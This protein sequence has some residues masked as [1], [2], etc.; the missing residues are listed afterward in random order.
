[1]RLPGQIFGLGRLL[2]PLVSFFITPPVGIFA[3]VQKSAVLIG[4]DIYNPRNPSAAKD[5]NPVV[6]R[7]SAKGNWSA[8][9]F[10][11][12]HGAVNDVELI[13]SILSSDKLGF[14]DIAVLKNQ[15]ATANAILATLQR[16]LVDET[17][18]GDIRVVFY[19]GHG[20]TV[21]NEASNERYRLDQTI[22]PGDH[23][24]GDVPHIRDKEL[25][26][27]LWKAGKKGVKVIFIADSCHSGGLSRGVWNQ[28]GMTRTARGAPA[29]D[30]KPYPVQISDPADKDSDTGKDINPV[31]VGVVFLAAAQDDESA[32]ENDD[33]P[34]GQH[35]AFTWALRKALEQG[36]DQPADL[37][38]RRATSLLKA[39]N[40]AQQPDLRG[41]DLHTTTL[42]GLPANAVSSTT[43]VVESVDGSGRV[44]RLRGG[45]AIGIYEGSELKRILNPGG[46][47]EIKITASLDL[48]RS[49]A[50]KIGSGAAIH[51]NDVFEVD[52][53][54]IPD[55]PML[56]VYMPPAAPS[57]IVFST[58]S[59][60]GKLRSE[61]MVHWVSDSSE[62]TPGQV[63]HWDGK[64]W[65]L[66]K[67]P[68]TGASV[69]LGTSPTADQVR[70]RLDGN[71]SFLLILPPTPALLEDLK[72]KPTSDSTQASS[73]KVLSEPGGDQYR[74]IGRVG[75]SGVEYAWV[76]IDATEES[77]RKMAN[78]KSAAE[79]LPLPLRTDWVGLGGLPESTTRAGSDLTGKAFRLG[80]LRA[81]LTLLAPPEGSESTSPFPYHLAFREIGKGKGSFVTTNEMKGGLR[82]KMYL[83]ASED[84]IQ[85]GV[86]DRW[87]YIFAIDRYGKGTLLFPALGE[88]NAGNQFPRKKNGKSDPQAEIQVMDTQDYDFEVT[89]PFGVDTYFL[90][91]SKQP[92]EDPQIFQF[93][94]VRTKGATR[95]IGYQDRLTQLLSD[96]GTSTTRGVKGNPAVPVS[97]G[98]EQIPILSVAK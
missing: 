93:D 27:I 60:V 52:K 86:A 96:I 17:T 43:A 61:K 83:R 81:W 78:E 64:E 62:A 2:P 87:V 9:S 70:G 82:Y 51:V 97:W 67:Y 5:T 53:W 8:W 24:R 1:M 85:R 95:G 14:K 36:L 46:P 25:S 39:D 3:A 23:Y 4:I 40:F 68:A 22:V 89:E 57:D 88:G 20:S 72:L 16:K 98:L 49:E 38:V 13:Q 15:D 76:Q 21:R 94:G 71:A 56:N 80:R 45:K 35:G 28:R 42:F 92:I 41:K 37:V 79:R 6:K 50:Q 69:P 47:V 19:S 32:Q 58:A 12:L 66:D 73:I 18:K 65:V 7:P 77:V 29:P 44:I 59:E 75:E 34:E 74:L 10:P 54:V 11:D 48:V 26:R 84:D 90:L 33:T 63:M 91:T 30:A 55:D 31:D